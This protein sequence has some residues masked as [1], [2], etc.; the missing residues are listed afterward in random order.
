MPPDGR[1]TASVQHGRAPK[2]ISELPVTMLACSQLIVNSLTEHVLAARTSHRCLR[3][4][5]QQLAGQLLR[6]DLII[7]QLIRGQ[8]LVQVH[9]DSVAGPACCLGMPSAGRYAE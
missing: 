2:A 1:Q 4:A 6:R 3:Q 7:W 5:L 9:A 8:L